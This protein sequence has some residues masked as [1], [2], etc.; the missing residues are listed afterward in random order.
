MQR[1]VRRF[2]RAVQILLD[3]NADLMNVV[4]DLAGGCRL[5]FGDHDLLYLHRDG[6]E[7]REHAVGAWPERSASRRPTPFL[8]PSFHGA[9]RVSISLLVS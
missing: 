5:L 9:H 3:Y 4:S 6:V 8:Y 1:G 7:L 2:L